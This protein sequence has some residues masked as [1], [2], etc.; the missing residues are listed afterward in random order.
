MIPLLSKHRLIKS[1]YICL[2]FFFFG[3]GYY[4]ISY[5]YCCCYSLQCHYSWHVPKIQK[6]IIKNRRTKRC[7]RWG[8]SLIFIVDVYVARPQGLECGHIFNVPPFDHRFCSWSGPWTRPISTW[9]ARYR[10]CLSRATIYSLTF[11]LP[12]NSHV[13]ACMNP[14]GFL[15]SSMIRSL[16]DLIIW[17]PIES[18][19]SLFLIGVVIF[20]AHAPDFKVPSLILFL[21]IYF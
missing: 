13:I 15:P 19:D 21:I 4:K 16:I 17:L 5:C 11:A 3:W 2:D 6:L 10:M 8:L 12:F 18:L 9:F 1:R 7:R 20:L 14:H